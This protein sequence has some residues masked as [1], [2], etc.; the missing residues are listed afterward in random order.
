MTSISPE[1]TDETDTIRAFHFENQNVR[2]RVIKLS[3][4]IT[5]I[6][7]A[8]AYPPLIANILAEALTITATLASFLKYDGIFTLQTS[9]DGII[10][11]L[12]CDMTSEGHLRGYAQYNDNKLQ[13]AFEG[14]NTPQTVQE[15]FGKGYLA[16]TVDQG[17][18]TERYQGIVPLE[19]ETLAACAEDYFMH[20]EQ[21]EC[22]IKLSTRT[23]QQPTT[24]WQTGC[25]VLQKM[26]SVA[27]TSRIR[28]PQGEDNEDAWKRLQVLLATCTDDELLSNTITT[29]TLLYR[30]FHEDT[31]RVFDAQKV[32]AQCRCA[33]EKV[34]FVLVGISPEER[35]AMQQDGVISATCQF[36]STT[37]TFADDDFLSVE[38]QQ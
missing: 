38:T 2:G 22:V 25:L 31:V 7:N 32:I 9:G 19:G 18:K 21:I 36:C 29:D 8:H 23:I 34:L 28:L 14:K 5:E 11:M 3:E 27:P 37:Y 20:S 16:F 15:L 4:S 1:I 6:I 10:K 12:V 17:D 26:P 35:K 33:R 13:R 30:L 24:I